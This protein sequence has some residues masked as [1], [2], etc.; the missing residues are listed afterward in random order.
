MSTRTER[1]L[2]PIFLTTFLTKNF[3]MG[4]IPVS[5]ALYDL[6][7]GNN[8]SKEK[9]PKKPKLSYK[10]LGASECPEEVEERI[11]AFIRNKGECERTL[12]R[13]DPASTLNYARLAKV[14][15]PREEGEMFR[16]GDYV[17][18]SESD[19]FVLGA[20]GRRADDRGAPC[21]AAANMAPRHH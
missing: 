7:V 11:K 18:V 17:H 10:N 2:M 1:W 20:C 4:V 8:P 9:H 13:I 5:Q 21:A 14:L 12:A 3:W 15:R 6:V 16:N 19:A